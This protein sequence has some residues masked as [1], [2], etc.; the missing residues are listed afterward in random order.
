MKAAEIAEVIKKLAPP[1]LAYEGEEM[2]FIVG[3]ENHEVK[4][5]GVT[6]RPTIKVLQ[7]AAAQKVDMLITHE[8]LYQ[9][10]KSFLVDPSELEYPPNKKREELVAQGGFC[11]Y[12]L[13]SEWDDAKE[14]NNETLAKLLG[15]EI[16]GKLPYG[17]IGRIKQT[18]L[19]EFAQKVIRSLNCH[20]VL[21]V[22]EDDKSITKVAVVAGSGNSLTEI[23]E[24]VKKKGADVL[25][26]GDIQ[27]SRARFAKELDLAVIDA[28]DYYTENPG[29]KHLAK[30]L[31]KELPDI[32]VLHLDPGP[33]W[34]VV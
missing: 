21:V 22:G 7:E 18:T 25:V 28:G 12:R 23:M 26:S 10:K 13:H 27:D 14:G 30:L 15:L 1:E 31:Q 4:I 9:S 33:P 24:L 17:R 16:T 34:R 3:D 2:G 20:N 5:V 19:K 32:K 29:A 8:P 6:E 11:V